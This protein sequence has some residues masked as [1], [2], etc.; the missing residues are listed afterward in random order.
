GLDTDPY[1]VEKAQTDLQAKA[2]IMASL[3]MEYVR[4]I[5]FIPG[6]EQEKFAEFRRVLDEIFLDAV[7]GDYSA[8]EAMDLAEKEINKILR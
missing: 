5:G 3:S 4:D 6:L 7:K 2:Q 8:Q 1:F